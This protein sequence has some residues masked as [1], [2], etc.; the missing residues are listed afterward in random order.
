MKISL[1]IQREPFGE[2]LARTLSDFF[3]SRFGVPRMVEWWETQSS[4]N[5]NSNSQ[6]WFCNPYLNAI[7]V[8][9]VRKEVFL[10]VIQEFSRSTKWWRRPFQ[11][12]YVDLS[13]APMTR[14]WFARAALE[15]SPPLAG[16]ENLLMLGGNHHIRLLDYNEGVAFVIRKAG[17]DR[18]LLVNDIHVRRENPYLP[19]PRIQDIAEDGSWYSEE[20]ILGL[21]VNRLKDIEQ[22]K[23]AVRS[24]MVSLLQLYEKTAQRVKADEY[25]CEIIERIEKRIRESPHFDKETR[26]DISENLRSLKKIINSWQSKEI[27]IAQSHGDFQPANIL[28]GKEK[29]W[30]IDWEYTGKRQVAYDGLVFAL[31]ARFAERLGQRLSQA[32]AGNLPECEQLMAAIPYAQWQVRDERCTILTLFLLED[33]ELKVMEACNSMFFGLDQGFGL[34]WKEVKRAIQVIA[35]AC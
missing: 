8:P 7:F 23:E 24:T 31:K 33:M 19:S 27:V 6:I 35:G 3:Q 30:L 1:L 10:P 25:A 22:G 11:K 34:F 17:F 4:G 29:T 14:R 15:I 21:P 20:L 12:V 2:I 26:G 32:M 9:E 16:A 18:E 5:P 13:A 28:L